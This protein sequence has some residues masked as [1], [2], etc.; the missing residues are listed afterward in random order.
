MIRY[1][2]CLFSKDIREELYCNYSYSQTNDIHYIICLA[3]IKTIK[4]E[5]TAKKYYFFIKLVKN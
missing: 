2:S 1:F 5:N 3:T 4:N